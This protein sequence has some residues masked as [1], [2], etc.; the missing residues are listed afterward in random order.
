MSNYVQLEIERVALLNNLPVAST[1]KSDVLTKQQVSDLFST[2]AHNIIGASPDDAYYGVYNN[3]AQLSD[4]FSDTHYETLSDV[5][6]LMNL[7]NGELTINESEVADKISATEE[8]I[9]NVTLNLALDN[10][11]MS[12]ART[13]DLV[14]LAT[15]IENYEADRDAENTRLTTEIN[16]V[17]DDIETSR[18][19]F[20]A[21]VY[22]SEDTLN[23]NLSTLA[24]TLDTDFNTFGV[25]IT[26]IN[27]RYND[28]SGTAI[29][30][31]G[32]LS[33]RLENISTEDSTLYANISTNLVNEEARELGVIND[34]SIRLYNVEQT[35]ITEI[36]TL[37]TLVEQQKDSTTIRFSDLSTVI[38]AHE[39]EQII[40][41][42]Y[43]S[44]TYAVGH[45][46]QWDVFSTAMVNELSNEEVRST[47]VQNTFDLELE[48]KTNSLLTDIRNK[49]DIAGGFVTGSGEF[50]TNNLYLGPFWRIKESG[51]TLL[52]QY[53]NTTSN[54]WHTVFPFIG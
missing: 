19:G 54:D 47:G 53:Y 43:I 41:L 16:N 9:S 20:K 28:L 12:S 34:L 17:I 32:A 15:S 22:T 2:E 50:K 14:N 36:Q 26:D 39:R 38:D 21:I 10:S 31:E 49:L 18:D 8:N 29:I 48:N 3:I 44:T 45:R 51:N 4:F 42:N 37:V 13:V 1:E 35:E 6:H 52:F 24:A 40:D 27:N 23:L 7:T 30:S 5:T 46:N 25:Q 11:E 33:L